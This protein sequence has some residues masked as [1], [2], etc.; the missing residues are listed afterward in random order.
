M[1][2]VVRQLNAIFD[3][4]QKNIKTYPV[5]WHETTGNVD[6]SNLRFRLESVDFLDLN[7]AMDAYKVAL[8]ELLLLL[9]SSELSVG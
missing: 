7:N 6:L 3:D 8:S 1:F 2:D 4:I 9:G 5:R